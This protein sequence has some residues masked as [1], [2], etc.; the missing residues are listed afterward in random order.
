MS[1][2][3]NT[4]VG[5][6]NALQNLGGINSR[7]NVVQN[8]IAT[9]LKV[10]SAIDDSSSFAIAQGIRGSIKAYS[11]VSQALATGRGIATV[12]LAGA[13]AIS[14]RRSTSS[15]ATPPTTAP[16]CCPPARPRSISWPMSTARP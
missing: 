15:S 14:D 2:S 16:I 5:A 6:Y 12:A 13:N 7:L 8:Q 11:A 9:G 4:N 10:S 3:V 1:T